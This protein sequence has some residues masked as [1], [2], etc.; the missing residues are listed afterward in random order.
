MAR[1]KMQDGKEAMTPPYF[2]LPTSYSLLPTPHHYRTAG[3]HSGRGTAPFPGDCFPLRAP[4]PESEMRR[5]GKTSMESIQ[6]SQ[7]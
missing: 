2:L 1:G 3:T 6:G 5:A 4:K 7:P